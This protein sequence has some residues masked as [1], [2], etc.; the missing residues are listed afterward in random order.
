[1]TSYT[2]SPSTSRQ[3]DV[4]EGHTIQKLKDKMQQIFH[5]RTHRRDPVTSVIETDFLSAEVNGNKESACRTLTV[6]SEH[7]HTQSS[8]GKWFS[9]RK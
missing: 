8:I 9:S 6:A 7:S 5:R 1:M 4:Q 3:C 2:P